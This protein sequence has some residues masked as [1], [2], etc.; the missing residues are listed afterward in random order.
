MIQDSGN[1]REFESG[2]VRDV[3]EGKGRMDLLPL[4]VISKI[5]NN[6]YLEMIDKF[7]ATKD[8]KHIE[9]AVMQFSEQYFPTP[10]TALMELSIHYEEGA[11]KYSEYNWQKGI[12]CHCYIDSG[13]RHMMKFFRGDTDE[14]HDRAFIW[15]MVGLLWTLK[16]KPELN[17]IHYHGSHDVE[18][19]FT[20][21][22]CCN[23]DAVADLVKDPLGHLK[24][25]KINEPSVVLIDEDKGEKYKWDEPAFFNFKDPG[26]E[27]H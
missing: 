25:A 21:T 9:D 17:D 1:R 7:L 4:D 22:A 10:E 24:P 14:R 20:F 23:P 27:L 2:A 18:E 3:Q 26:I 13:L 19:S 15:N 8:T 12:S 16:H 6:P 5:F 11:K